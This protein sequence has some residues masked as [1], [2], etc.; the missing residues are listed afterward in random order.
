MPDTWLTEAE[1]EAIQHLP[2]GTPY[3]IRGV[4][5][6]QFSIARHYGG[7]T[8]NGNSYT[9]NPVTDELIRDDVLK[10]VMRMRR[11]AKLAAKAAGVEKEGGLFW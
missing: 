8:W 6:G 1:T 7:A 9:Y 2:L 4:S 10:F 3:L 5:H 11:K